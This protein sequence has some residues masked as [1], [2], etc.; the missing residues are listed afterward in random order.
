MWDGSA[1]PLDENLTI[2]EELLERCKKANI[3]LEIEVG[4]VGGEEDGVENAIN[5][6]LY[7]TPEDAVATVARSGPARRAA[8]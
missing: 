7:S 5:D 4:V 1:V 8:T 3:V 2:A 6:K